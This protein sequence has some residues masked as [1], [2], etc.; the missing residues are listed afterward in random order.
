[1]IGLIASIVS[2]ILK[3]HKKEYAIAVQICTL[4]IL[5]AFAADMLSSRFEVF[6]SFLEEL[7][8]VGGIIKIMLKAA[9]ICVMTHFVYDICRESGNAAIADAVDFSGRAVILLLCL[10]LMEE[11]LKAALQFVK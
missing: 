5:G 10:P 2:L 8:D 9:V 3:E 7:A 6:M 11:L 1:M 4:I